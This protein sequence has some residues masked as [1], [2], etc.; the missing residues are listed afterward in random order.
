MTAWC[1][2]LSGCP[3]LH[4]G[5]VFSN[6]DMTGG[7]RKCEY[8]FIRFFS[9]HPYISSLLLVVEGGGKEGRLKLSSI[10]VL[11]NGDLDRALLHKS[12]YGI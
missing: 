5:E 1:K 4:R 10:E 9:T 12:I 8:P 2:Y 11:E 6:I 3:P 7:S